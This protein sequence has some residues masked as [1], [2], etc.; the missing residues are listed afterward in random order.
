MIFRFFGV[1]VVLFF[2]CLSFNIIR[3]WSSKLLIELIFLIEKIVS[4]QTEAF[5][6]SDDKWFEEVFIVHFVLS[7]SFIKERCHLFVRMLYLIKVLSYC[8]P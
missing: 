4:V 8:F 3:D 2:V 6:D 5:Y 7:L 1:F